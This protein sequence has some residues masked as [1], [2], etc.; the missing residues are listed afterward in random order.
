[1]HVS[2]NRFETQM[3]EK[4]KKKFPTSKSYSRNKIYLEFHGGKFIEDLPHVLTD[5]G[6]C[7][8]IVTLGSGFNGSTGH[9][10]KCN[11]VGQHPHCLVERAEPRVNESQ[12]N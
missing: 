5:N 8:F 6:P 11:H 1:M 12:N 4:L 9:I 2:H 10:I 7:N 3:I